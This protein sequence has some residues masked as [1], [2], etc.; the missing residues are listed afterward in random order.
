MTQITSYKDILDSKTFF[1]N[2]LIEF[3][4]IILFAIAFHF[5]GAYNATRLL[6]LS[7]VVSTMV[8]YHLEKRIPYITLYITFLTTLFGYMTLHKHN[9]S[10]L[11]IRDSVYD[12]TLAGTLALGILFNISFLKISLSTYLTLRDLAWRYFTY[13]WI[14]FF[15]VN[16]FL[17]ELIR[18]HTS[19]SDW[20]LYKTIMIPVTIVFTII[21]LHA[22]LRRNNST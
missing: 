6:M 10:F 2:I 3:G 16:G 9:I 14:G 7:T 22:T 20:L 4:P 11:Q 19:I 18:K 8:I 1:R 21:A 5:V 17:N 12:F 15:L 13:T